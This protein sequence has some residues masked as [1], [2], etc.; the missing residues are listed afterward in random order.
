MRHAVILLI[1]GAVPVT[2]IGEATPANVVWA[3]GEADHDHAEF[4]LAPVQYAH[5]LHQDFGWPDRCYVIGQSQPAEDWPYVLP[6]PDDAWAGSG[7][8]AGI[9]T[10]TAEI[11]FELAA[12]PS[13]D[14]ALVIEL[15]DVSP[16]G[17]P[18][19]R[20]RVNGKPHDFSLEA[21]A[22]GDSI[23]GHPEQG[24]P[25]RLT[26]PADNL[27][28][29]VN[30]VEM[31]VLQGSWLLFD[32]VR[33]EGPGSAA[34]ANPHETLIRK[35]TPSTFEDQRDGAHVQ[36]LLV[37]VQQVAGHAKLVVRLDD[38][39]IFTA[40]VEPGR[41]IFEAPMPAAGTETESR[42]TVLVDGEP[43]YEGTVKRAPGKKR[44][45]A[46]YVDV[47]MG[48]GHS[49]WMI[50]PGPWMPY[51]M[52]KL[53]PENQN[54]GWQGGY[55]PTIENVAG[56]SHIH[57][58]T[59]AGLLTMP[60]TGPLQTEVGDQYHPEEGYRSR[61]D[62]DRE[63]GGIGYYHTYL[64]D[65]GIDAELTATTR[66][67]LQRYTFPPTDS[68]RVLIDLQIPAEYRYDLEAC[69]VERVNDHRIEGYSQQHSSRVWF[70]SHQDYTV[71]FVLEFDRPMTDFGVWSNG[72]V[73]E[74][75]TLL[76][77]RQ[78]R[79]AGA[80]AGFDLS[81]GGAVLM[82][83]AIS[84]V[85]V[86]QAQRN[87][88]T[89]MTPF[90]W[91]FDAVVEQQRDAW[92]TIFN[93]IEIETSDHREKVR[94]Y[95]NLYRAYCA[96]TIWSDVNGQWTGP[97]EAIHQLP[98]PKSPV[99]GCDAF[100]NTF[101]NLNQVWNLLTPEYS[102]NWVR[103]QLALYDVGG[104]LAKGPAGMEY[105]PVMVAEHEIPFIVAAY[106]LGIR[107]FDAEKAFE[108]MV[109]M[110]TA[111]WE[112]DLG[113]GQAGNK[114]LDVYLR[115]GYVPHGG[116]NSSN[117]M[118]Y[119]YDDYCVAQMAKA[120]GKQDAYDQF[121]ARAQNWKNLIDPDIGFARPK[122]A[123]GNWIE[124][125]EPLQRVEGWTEGNAWQYTWFVPHDPTALIERIGQ[126]R[127]VANLNE[128]FEK[129]EPLRYNAPLEQYWDYPVC[130]GNQPAMQVSYLFNYAGRPWLTQHW[131][132]SIQERYYGHGVEDAYLGDE[133]QGQMS[134]WFIMSAIGLFQTD[135]GCRVDPIYE[136]ASP[137]FEKV[138][139]HLNPD[140]YPGK[141]FVI[142]A[143]NASRE[144]A[145]VQSAKLNGETLNR[146]W[147]PA[148]A[149]QQGG[150]LELE[151][152][153]EPNKEWART[154]PAVP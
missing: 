16:N 36:P 41:T 117:T 102:A 86:E 15:V 144:N 34:L 44:T 79:D 92:N 84:L 100:W 154:Q 62:K 13:G 58:W 107:D 81:E 133:D 88:E 132:R 69:R 103:S 66:A 135:G 3:L 138:T 76:K 146:W 63:N 49:R 47:F 53:S 21:G 91:D 94:F 148:K 1:L 9:R 17:P 137:R 18:F 23:A 42:V 27:C 99:Y 108:A 45:P 139:I 121:M 80:Y 105:I 111:P 125:Y 113:G 12:C 73:R 134:G 147:F 118:E 31:S 65:Y 74:G 97:E 124:P 20:V 127:F 11:L 43:R 4:A 136:I 116:G 141:T 98:D 61:I 8:L 109:K 96:R 48:T 123:E 101:W 83:S 78:A 68:A 153:P 37:D 70:D 51:G 82:R 85:S 77:T 24:R 140:Y 55:E 40:T 29:G 14:Y 10:H 33:L 28:A 150:I 143:H 54:A 151:M 120:L 152:G 2:A 30:H 59:M 38:A 95:S 32:Q 60:V 56:F 112:D 87:L 7:G 115:L 5:Y 64:S 46:D 75:T 122:D 128:G 67:G 35:V 130:H 145:Y 114:D 52:V 22:S 129:S 89:E 110:Q 39:E 71:Y 106:Q 72:K 90:G 50:A 6:G 25:V 19:L 131:N 26:V 142:E 104:W 93:R 149:L 119:A 126:D 57:E